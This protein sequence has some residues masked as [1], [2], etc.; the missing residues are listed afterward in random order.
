[1]PP[2]TPDL[3]GG[4][5]RHTPAPTPTPKACASG[6]AT[7]TAPAMTVATLAAVV[8]SFNLT[9]AL[10]LYGQT[11]SETELPH[12]FVVWRP[13]ALIQLSCYDRARIFRAC[14]LQS[15]AVSTSH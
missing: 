1:M 9:T 3:R 13:V 12:W 15:M 14:E 10:R 5:K 6:A 4:K 8:A 2:Q 7:G 11:T